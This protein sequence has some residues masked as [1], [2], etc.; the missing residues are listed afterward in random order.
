MR[1][2]VEKAAP[3]GLADRLEVAPP[4]LI[5][6]APGIPDAV[7]I[8]VHRPLAHEVHR[9]DH[10]VEVARLQEIG[11]PLLGSRHEVRLYTQPQVGV[12]AHE[13]AVLVKVVV[14]VLTPERVPPHIERLLEAVDVLGDPQLGDPPLARPPSDS[15]RRWPA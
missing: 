2:H 14:C 11:D 13:R 10:V 1:E 6:A 12:L 15:A 9:A 8:H 4:Y 5:S 3:R 7:V